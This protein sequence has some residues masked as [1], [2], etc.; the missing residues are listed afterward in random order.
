MLPTSLE[1]VIAS[2]PAALA[3]A[4][5]SNSREKPAAYSIP[6]TNLPLLAMLT[7]VSLPKPLFEA[8]PPAAS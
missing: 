3:L 4:C 6:F 2:A 8:T 1:A 7:C 5:P